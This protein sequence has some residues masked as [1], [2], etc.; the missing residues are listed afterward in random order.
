MQRSLMLEMVM[1]F[2]CQTAA[3]AYGSR[4]ALRLS[5]TTVVGGPG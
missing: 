3:A 2:L 4:I 5:G 1:A